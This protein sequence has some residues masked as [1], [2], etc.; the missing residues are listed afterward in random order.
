M[1]IQLTVR[2]SLSLMFSIIFLLASGYTYS[3]RNGITGYS[4]NPNSSNGGSYCSLCHNSGVI[5]TVT[6]T[7]SSSVTPGS[8]NSYQ[9]SVSGGQQNLA[10]FNVSANAGTLQIITGDTTIAKQNN[11]L[12]HSKSAVTAAVLTWNF[13]WLAPTI[14][15]SYKLYGAGLSANNDQTTTGDNAAITSLT[16]V[17]AANG[18]TPVAKIVAPLTALLD[19][20]ITFDGSS[21][22]APSGVTITQYDWNIDGTDYLNSGSSYQTNFTTKGRHTATLTVTDSNN[23]TAVTFA[24]VIIGDRTVP[25]VNL[26]GPFSGETT[27]A[28]N[29]DASTSTSDASTTITN[30]IWD[31]GDGSVIQQGSTATQS[32]AY[33]TAGN[34]VVTIVAQDGNGLSGVNNAA[35]TII[36][37]IPPPSTGPD[38]YNAKCLVCHGANGSGTTSVPKIIEGATQAQILNAIS[39]VTQMNAITLSANEAQL[40]SD[41]LAVTGTSGDA[42]YRGNCQLCH[43]VAGIGITGVAPPVIGSTRLLISNKISTVSSMNAIV[44]DTT[45]LQAIA[46]FLGSTNAVTGSEF[47]ANKCAICHGASGTGIIAVAPSV[48]GATQNMIASAITKVAIM[49]GIILSN[50]NGQLIADFLGGGGST[51]QELYIAKCTI[52]HGDAGIGRLGYGP[53]VK[54]ATS[55]MIL[56]KVNTVVEMQGIT[57]TSQQIQ[58]LADYLGSGGSTGQD[59]YSNKCALCHGVNATG[60]TGVAPAVQGATPSMIIS[61]ITNAAIMNGIILTAADAQLIADFIG[62]G[63]TTG[64]ELYTI[65]CAICHGDAGIGRNGYGP[66]VKGATLNMI[67]SEIKNVTEMQGISLTNQ[68]TQ[69]IA[70]YLGSGGLT[71]QD[72]YTNKCLLCHGQN[73]SG[74]SGSYG[75]PNIQKDTAQKFISAI[76][77][78]LEM[79]GILLT[80]QEAQ[81]I[82]TF[83]N[84]GQ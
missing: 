83:L 51:G 66:F 22:T 39:S 9:F 16:I 75:G 26:N 71:G 48:I 18:P 72:Y 11:E 52:C 54:G 77:K 81:E 32:H 47:Y 73:G 12:T 28:I 3:M 80:A 4:G 2:I 79:N 7:G 44:L 20:S 62:S 15:G 25:V 69:L 82:E 31:F 68:Q 61:A 78:K 70:D 76:I 5:P 1:N 41:Y 27:I 50:T 67:S 65:K 21:S 13:K 19:S 14:A 24:D 6:L 64:Q 33:T 57:V 43:G 30:Y 10:G 38:I 17:V 55:S 60:I 59:F 23:T 29:F 63:G 53:V 8:L 42:L 56:D 36:T 49:D 45:G 84:V 34:Y 58:L 37:V 74:G 35:V 40:V 46:D